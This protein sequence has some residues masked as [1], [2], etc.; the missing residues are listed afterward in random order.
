MPSVIDNVIDIK[1]VWLT[2]FLFHPMNLLS[3]PKNGPVRIEW[4]LLEQAVRIR[5]EKRSHG[6]AVPLNSAGQACFGIP[7]EQPPHLCTD[8]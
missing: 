4:F 3:E 8:L 7:L 1:K 6:R 5:M 2:P